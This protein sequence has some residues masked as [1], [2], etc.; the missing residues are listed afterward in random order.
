MG[1]VRNH[2]ELMRNKNPPRL[3]LFHHRIKTRQQFDSLDRNKDQE[4][5]KFQAQN[6]VQP[7][8]SPPR[9]QGP[10]PRNTKSARR[11]TLDFSTTTFLRCSLN[12]RASAGEPKNNK[13]YASKRR[14]YTLKQSIL[15]SRT[16]IKAMTKIMIA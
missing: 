10:R 14:N 3:L 1:K 9:D 13:L 11:P 4:L 12:L 7:Q 8:E 2:P 5:F 15:N 16:S 6:L